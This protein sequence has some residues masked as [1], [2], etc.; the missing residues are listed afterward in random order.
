MDMSDT[1]VSKLDGL[2]FL[3]SAMVE[4]TIKRTLAQHATSDEL[5][6]E[7]VF[8]GASN[9]ANSSNYE[10]QF[11]SHAE[12]SCTSEAQ[13]S[14][15]YDS[16]TS[17]TPFKGPKKQKRTYVEYNLWFGK[18][19]VQ[20]V[21][22]KQSEI[23]T[24]RV[25]SASQ[26]R[27]TISPNLWFLRTSALFSSGGTSPSLGSPTLDLRFRI[28]NRVTRDSPIVKA[29][30][31]YD[32]SEVCQLLNNREATPFDVI[33]YPGGYER[34]LFD[35]ATS[36]LCKCLLHGAS[37]PL[38]SFQEAEALLQIAKLL[39]DSG[40][41]GHSAGRSVGHVLWT[42]RQT[43]K[44]EKGRME[45]ILC[46]FAQLIMTKS[47]TDPLRSIPRSDLWGS[48]APV[49]RMFTIGQEE[50]DLEECKE[51]FVRRYGEGSWQA[52]VL[53]C[54]DSEQ[55]VSRQCE[56]WNSEEL[57]F[58]SSKN[59]IQRKYGYSFI[60]IIWPEAFW[61]KEYLPIRRSKEAC[62]KRY[63]LDFVQNE[64]PFLQTQLWVREP[65]AIGRSR[66]ACLKLFG[67][68]FVEE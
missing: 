28:F 65:K 9:Q 29:I 26:K 36:G 31:A 38:V 37:D 15:Q 45:D 11:T 27:V 40:L 10:R 20:T 47:E 14:E 8:M 22:T 7:S 1:M 64:R 44:K 53:D 5:A 25:I 33:E 68:D 56:T 61:A 66:R 2:P 17:L 59:M 4:S 42:S 60:N 57:S 18:I 50:W 3:V 63:G 67:P 19:S 24:G 55:W 6:N 43:M 58:Q 21:I 41:D 49:L 52:S 12:A 62:I 16:S 23:H 48:T 39:A 13:P 35:I 32:Y 30:E 51:Y 46:D 54:L 34:G